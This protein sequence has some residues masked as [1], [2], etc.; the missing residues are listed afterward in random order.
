[1]TTFSKTIIAAAAVLACACTPKYDEG[2]VS[3]KIWEGYENEELPDFST[4]G[5]PTA[6]GTGRGFELLEYTAPEKNHFLAEFTST[7]TV[8]AEKEY[9]FLLYSDDCSRFIVDGDTLVGMNDCKYSFAGKTLGK[10][11]HKLTV[12]Y[13]ERDGGQGLDLYFY[14]KGQLPRDYGTQA[15]EYKIPDFV[16]PQVTEA[17]DRYMEWKGDDETVIF[18]IFTDVHAHTDYRFHH[19]GYIADASDIWNYDF[20]LCLG[21]VGVNLGPA[22][23]SKDITNTILTGISD[24][25]KKFHGIFLYV[26]GNHDWDGGEGTVTSEERFQELFQKPGLEKAGGNLHLTPGKV[27][28]YYDIPEKNFRIILLNSCGTCTLQDKYYVFDDEQVEWFKNLVN[29]TPKEMSILVACHY[30]PHPNGRWHNTPAPYN[31]QSN[32]R[33]MDVLAELKKS[34]NIIGLFCGDS[35]FNMHE[36][37]RNVNYFITQGLGFCTEA[38]LMPGTRRAPYDVEESLCCDVIAIKP[39]KGEV[40]TF[41]IGAGGADFDYEFKY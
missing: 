8:P 28:H 41:R 4:L 10:G 39:A 2:E 13:L 11:K 37:D 12:Q 36:V 6:T 30:M 40:H 5:E 9:T 7:L 29:D 17:H 16:V 23:I 26:P 34:H 27:Y 18:P 24:E 3:Y 20:M 15:P 21:D 33:M 35:H 31:L 19:I 25:M 14:E 38:Q 1:M 32:E 22:H